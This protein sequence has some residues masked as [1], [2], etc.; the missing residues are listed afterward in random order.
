MNKRGFSTGPPHF[1]FKHGSF[2]RFG[3]IFFFFEFNIIFKCQ[4]EHDEEIIGLVHY[5]HV[6]E[7]ASK[8]FEISIFYTSLAPIQLIFSGC[9]ST[10]KPTRYMYSKR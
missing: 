2:V 1:I 10:Q 9:F 5:S 3:M 7:M 6:Y 8:I 4:P